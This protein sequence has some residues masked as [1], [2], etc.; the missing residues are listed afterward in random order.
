MGRPVRS[1]LG[2]KRHISTPLESLISDVFTCG[3][4]AL[5]VLGVVVAVLYNTDWWPL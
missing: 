3:F 1:G 4:V 2:M 5:C